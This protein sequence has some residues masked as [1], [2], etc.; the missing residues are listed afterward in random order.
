MEVVGLDNLKPLF[1]E[2][3]GVDEPVAT[4]FLD[5]VNKAGSRSELATNLVKFQ[6]DL[7]TK[8]EDALAESWKAQ[9]DA[10]KAETAA[11]P[12]IGGANLDANLAKV[13]TVISDYAD[14]P[15]AL[16]EFFA[17]SGAGNNR[18]VVALLVKLAGA[19]PGEGK[20]VEGKPQPVE[21]SRADRLFG[22]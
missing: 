6:L 20:P 12:V 11:D 14:N 17:L 18:H 3:R 15:A 16:K 9:Q 7:Q 13:E 21:K 10:W 2:G 19:V 4:Q 8:S 1:P 5:I 22:G